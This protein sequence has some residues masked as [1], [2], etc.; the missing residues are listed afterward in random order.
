[1]HKQSFKSEN[2]SQTSLSKFIWKLKKKGIKYETTWKIQDRGVPFNPLTNKCRLCTKEKFYILFKPERADINSRDEIFTPCCHRK[3]KLLIP[4]ERKKKGPGWLKK[5]KHI[6]LSCGL[7]YRFV[8]LFDQLF[9]NAWREH[10]LCLKL[11]SSNTND[12]IIW[13]LFLSS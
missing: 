1:M 2:I 7:V 4:P 3:S 12:S 13:L 8:T 6:G 11:A 10:R 5:W 9:V